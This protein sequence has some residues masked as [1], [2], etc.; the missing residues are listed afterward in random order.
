MSTTQATAPKSPGDR[1][2][3]GDLRAATAPTTTGFPGQTASEKG[4]RATASSPTSATALAAMQ[5]EGRRLER[6][7]LQLRPGR[8]AHPDPRNGRRGEAKTFTFATESATPRAPTGAK[9][10]GLG[11]A[12]HLLGAPINGTAEVR[13]TFTYRA[14]QGRVR[15]L[16]PASTTGVR[17]EVRNHLCL[18]QPRQARDARYPTCLRRLSHGDQPRTQTLTTATGGWWRRIP[19]R[20]AA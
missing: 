19:G 4:T 1:S 6:P 15:S 18:Q 10:A 5:T 20:R 12:L 14:T 13:D 11:V 8:A 17:G 3:H 7:H 9:R 16:P 2:R